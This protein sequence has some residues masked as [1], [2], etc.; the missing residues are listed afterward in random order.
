MSV[1]DN[2]GSR[3][4]PPPSSSPHPYMA[5]IGVFSVITTALSGIEQNHALGEM[6]HVWRIKAI[7]IKFMLLARVG[8]LYLPHASHHG[9]GST[10]QKTA[11][12]L[13]ATDGV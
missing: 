13:T 2:R 10:A 7:G 11:T 1:T 6:K 9:E 12:D 3:Q 5:L 8:G 4:R